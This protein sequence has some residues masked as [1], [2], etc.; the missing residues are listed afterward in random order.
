MSR[1]VGATVELFPD[2]LEPPEPAPP[3]RPRGSRMLRALARIVLWSLIVLG[4]VRGLH[5]A[6]A[7]APGP[8]LPAGGAGDSRGEAV[9]AAFVR[10]YLTVG[11]DRAARDRRLAQFTVAGLDLRRSVSVPTS[12]NQYVDQ[13]VVAGSRPLD[14]GVEVTVLAHLLHQRTDGYH[15]G[16]TLA[17]AVPLTLRRQGVAVSGPPRPS[18]L[19]TA[20]GLVLGRP[21]AVPDGLSRSA[22]RMARRAVIALIA[23]D[24]A[25]LATLGGGRTPTIHRLPGGWKAIS[26]GNAKVAAASGGLVAEVPVR[27]RPPT[28]PASYL[29]PVRVRLEAHP[30]GVVVREVDAG[31]AR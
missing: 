26:V 28:G 1:P 29:V 3:V 31:G 23:A 13:V 15:D 19:P 12:D 18:P 17:L 4:A 25:T 20:P 14:G 22:G 7:A 24:T 5:P 2:L 11:G 10:E 6:P 9:A 8:E 30:E 16:G 27:I 21:R